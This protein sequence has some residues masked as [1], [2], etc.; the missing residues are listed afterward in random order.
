VTLAVAKTIFI[1]FLV[2]FWIIRSP[3]QRRARRIPVRTSARGMREWLLIASA[4]AGLAVIPAFYVFGPALRFAD[5]RFQPLLAWIGTAVLVFALAMFYL[6]HRDLGRNF[7]PSLD[8]RTEHKLVTGGVYA[9]VRHPMYSGFWLWA[10]AQALMLPNWIAG[11]AGLV[12]FGILYAFRIGREEQ[13]MVERFGAEYR[14]YMERT[15]RIVP[16]I[17]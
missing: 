12:G 1:A 10:I 5:Y 4:T 15:G 11:F 6:S 8:V 7:S 9:Y 16:W 3:H 17:L 14:G 13:L 2:V